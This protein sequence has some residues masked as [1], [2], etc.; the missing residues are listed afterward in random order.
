M[1]DLIS[2]THKSIPVMKCMQARLAAVDRDLREAKHAASVTP[3]RCRTSARAL[4][5]EAQK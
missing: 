2:K 1:L 4:M 3:E 5:C